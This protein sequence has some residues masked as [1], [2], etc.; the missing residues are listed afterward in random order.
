MTQR[1]HLRVVHDVPGGRGAGSHPVLSGPRPEME[2]DMG[3]DE[4]RLVLGAVVLVGVVWA[5]SRGGRS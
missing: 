4:V 1:G 5:I 3:V 2:M